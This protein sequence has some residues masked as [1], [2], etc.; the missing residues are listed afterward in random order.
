MDVLSSWPCCSVLYTST[1][2]IHFILNT[3]SNVQCLLYILHLP[4][5]CEDFSTETVNYDELDFHMSR[6]KDELT[7]ILSLA[8]DRITVFDCTTFTQSF[9]LYTV[10]NNILNNI[11]TSYHYHYYVYSIYIIIYYISSVS[12]TK[13]DQTL[14][15]ATIRTVQWTRIL[16]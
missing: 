10:H 8:Q 12:S 6:P 5:V 1:T 2:G 13:S 16:H 7:I 11:S 4:N 15:R 14:T 9:P 3:T